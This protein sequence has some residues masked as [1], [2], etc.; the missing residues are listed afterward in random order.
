MCSNVLFA[1]CI[2]GIL[3]EGSMTGCASKCLLNHLLS[4][5]GSSFSSCSIDI[6][7]TVHPKDE[8][9]SLLNESHSVRFGLFIPKTIELI[10]T[11]YNCP[12]SSS[13]PEKPL[14]PVSLL[15]P[16]SRENQVHLLP[17]RKGNWTQVLHLL[18]KKGGPVSTVLKCHVPESLGQSAALQIPTSYQPF[19]CR[20]E[21]GW[22]F[23]P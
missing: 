4:I 11:K 7:N 5:L 20:R 17:G 22:Y 15:Y 8:K 2:L 1:I 14:S 23:F 10:K 3:T 13:L 6:L 16:Q 19:T 18:D 21:K 9:P 12:R